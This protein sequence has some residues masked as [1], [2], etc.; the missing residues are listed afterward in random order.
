M[1]RQAPAIRSLLKFD[2]K[3]QELNTFFFSNF[4]GA[5]PPPRNLFSLG[6]EG[7]SSVA[8]PTPSTWKTPTQ[9]EDIQTKR[10]EF[11]LIFLPEKGR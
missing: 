11:V 6:F 3:E 10:F 2:Y 7:Y 1:Y 9:W 5:P 8:V 4:S